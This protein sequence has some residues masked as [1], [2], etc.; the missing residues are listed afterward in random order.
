MVLL[1]AVDPAHLQ[2]TSA[3]MCVNQATLSSVVVVATS[4]PAMTPPPASF[5][6]VSCKEAA[7]FAEYASGLEGLDGFL[8]TT[9]DGL[10]EL[11]NGAEV[12]V[13]VSA[14]YEANDSADGNVVRA[15]EPK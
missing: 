6:E 10:V 5:D 11:L 2:S 13:P 12:L 14:E 7:R 3:Q 8:G 9:A 15:W 4:A 1:A